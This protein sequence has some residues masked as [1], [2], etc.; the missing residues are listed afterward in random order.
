MSLKYKLDSLD[1]LDDATKALYEK[2]GD[3]YV[4]KVEGV[5]EGDVVGLKNKVETLLGETSELKKKIK[6]K[7]DAEATAREEERKAKEEAAAKKG[8]IEGLRKSADERVANKE[9][10]VRGELEPKLQKQ[11]KTIRRL[12]V[13]NVAK[14]MATRIGLKGSESLL[15]PHIT[16]RL[17]VEERDG[18]LVTVIKGADGKASAMSIT[19][20]ETEFKGNTAFAPVLAGSQGSG[21]GA[22]GNQSKGGGAAGAKQIKRSEFDALDPA[23]KAAKMK[24]GFTVTD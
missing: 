21:G 10:E 20:L 15:I 17:D 22:G 9:K 14:D 13:D 11:D 1:G 23:G 7:E 3:K 19:D 6:E 24:E 2:K 16:S 12:L 8:D 18:E 5:E 4:L